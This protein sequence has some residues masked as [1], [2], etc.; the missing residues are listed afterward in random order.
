MYIYMRI[1]IHFHPYIYI[2]RGK[3]VGDKCSPGESVA[4]IET[5]KASMVIYIFIYIYICTYICM[6][7]Y[8]DRD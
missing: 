5:D 8:I 4:E 1:F 7:I 2:Y 3:A 6:Y